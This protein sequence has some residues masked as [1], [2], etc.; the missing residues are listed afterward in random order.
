MLAA[1]MKNGVVF[2]IRRYAIH[3]GPGIR[4]T[5]FFKGCPLRCWWCHNP[6]GQ[7][8]EP[9]LVYRESRCI[10]C[11]ECLRGC[12]PEAISLRNQSISVNRDNCVLCGNCCR[13]CPSDALSIAGKQMTVKE[14]LEEIERDRAFY[15]E[16]GGG[17]TFSGGEPLL[18]PD[19]LNTLL[20]E[21]KKKRHP[22]HRRHVRVRTIRNH[23]RNT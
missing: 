13:V 18:Q 21:C 20:T 17:V 16:S 15:E 8:I 4:T 3:D 22:H 9:E 2:D 1:P 11:G 10:G 23:R 5:V 19:F 7:H 12:Q 14:I 6:E